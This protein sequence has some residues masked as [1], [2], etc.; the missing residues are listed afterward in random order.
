MRC[1]LQIEK[2][3]LI[4]SKQGQRNDLTTVSRAT[5]VDWPS[6]KFES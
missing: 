6:R 4:E 1:E 5:E 3:H 2:E